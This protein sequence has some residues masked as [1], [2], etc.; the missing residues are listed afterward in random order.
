VRTS[1]WNWDLGGRHRFSIAM[2]V[3]HGERHGLG[4]GETNVREAKSASLH[5]GWEENCLLM[6]SCAGPMLSSKIKIPL[7]ATPFGLHEAPPVPR[8]TNYS[9][10]SKI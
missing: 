7:S 1:L 5:L 8:P 6:G 3:S 10:H 2:E 4:K 9:L